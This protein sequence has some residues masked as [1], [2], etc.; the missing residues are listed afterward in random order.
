M[1]HA[2]I[3]AALGGIGPVTARLGRHRTRASTWRR[4]G[5][6]IQ[7]WLDI[8]EFARE[9]GIPGIT[10]EVLRAGYRDDSPVPPLPRGR[11]RKHSPGRP[12]SATH[13]AASPEAAA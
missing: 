13:D 1:R 6:P 11:R 3:I 12:A 7:Y 2:D 5:I 8:V 10:M 4:T 9:Q